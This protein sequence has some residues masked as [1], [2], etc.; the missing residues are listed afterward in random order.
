MALRVA[1]LTP[2]ERLETS[3]RR[4]D[5]TQEQAAS[6]YGVTLYRYI[7]W[8][9]GASDDGIPSP[10]LKVLHDYEEIR[11]L[12][13]RMGLTLRAMA[14]KLSVSH[15]WLQMVENNQGVTDGLLDRIRALAA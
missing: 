6:T 3:R 5:E 13:R 1:D 15:Q 9:R 12:R 14:A 4:G 11:I 2:A 8:E 10:A 7:Q